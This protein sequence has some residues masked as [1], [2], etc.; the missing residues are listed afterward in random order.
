MPLPTQPEIPA[1]SVHS[2]VQACTG[3]RTKRASVDGALG[4]RPISGHIRPLPPRSVQS[5]MKM[6]APPC[7]PGRRGPG[8]PRGR[9][10]TITFGALQAP[11]TWKCRSRR[12]APSS[13]ARGRDKNRAPVD[14]EPPTCPICGLARPALPCSVRPC[15]KMAASPCTSGR[16]WSQGA[17]EGQPRL[18]HQDVGMVNNH[19]SQQHARVPSSIARAFD[20]RCNEA[21]SLLAPPERRFPSIFHVPPSISLSFSPSRAWLHST[22]DSF[23]HQRFPPHLWVN[24]GPCVTLRLTPWI[25]LHASAL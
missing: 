24:P 20:R 14:G 6:R 1:E 17:T 13:Y 12:A 2:S 7:T 25:L 8:G 15:M 5:C 10:R 19:L 23:M 9:A 16:R 3:S 21:A 18:I 4:T 11:A 22:P